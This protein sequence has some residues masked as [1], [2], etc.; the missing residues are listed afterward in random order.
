MNPMRH[1][2]RAIAVATIAAALAGCVSVFPKAE[3]VGLYRFGADPAQ[4]SAENTTGPRLGVLKTATAFTRASASDRILTITNGEAAY[5]AD[6]RWVSPASILFDEAVSR[7]FEASSGRAR[8]IGR[9]EVT[10]VDLTLRLEVRSFETVYVN[11]PRSTPEV[12]I[13]VRGVLNRNSDGTLVGDKIF[14]A[15]IKSSTNRVGPIVQAYDAATSKVLGDIIVWVAA[16]G[17][18]RGA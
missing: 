1:S 9:G 2:L 17:A 16:S 14:E 15:R 3:P 7:A 4:A 8:L 6:A 10:K 13:Q 5:I 12:L 11:G 18:G